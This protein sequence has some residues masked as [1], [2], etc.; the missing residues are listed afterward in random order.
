M[1][2]ILYRLN[3]E[4]AKEIG[5]ENQD[6]PT[7]KIE[8]A[9]IS[10][11]LAYKEND[12][13]FEMA[14]TS[15]DT[16]ATFTAVDEGVKVI[17]SH[18]EFMKVAISS[19]TYATANLL[20]VGLQVKVVSVNEAENKVYVELAGAT[21]VDYEANLK[22][23]IN[24]EFKRLLEKG[25]KPQVWG[26]VKR[27]TKNRVMID[28]LGK[29]IL[30]FLDREEWS[31]DYLRNLE[32]VCQVGQY[33]QVEV[34]RKAPKVEGKP[35]A[36]L[37]SRKAF[38]ESA[39]D[40]VDVEGLN[41]NGLIL[42]RCTEKPLGKTYWWGVSDAL[43]GID[44]LGD[45]TSPFPNADSLYVGITYKCKIRKLDKAARKISVKPFEVIASDRPK[46]ERVKML[47]KK[48]PTV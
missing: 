7:K 48:A 34:I 29:G 26:V 23:E 46:I 12:Q 20:G 13:I 37:L 45:F 18:E 3:K 40:S 1:A 16:E 25:T 44:I 5:V 39:W 32:A 43:P 27:V 41:E 8:A 31:V 6:A 9:G 47:K 38:S 42:V 4:I 17:L 36:W 10:K 2:S 22:T 14:F 35:T 11:Y 24:E 30:G 28:L 19:S 21:K 15:V 33:L